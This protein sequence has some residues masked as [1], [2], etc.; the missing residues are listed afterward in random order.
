[1]D[2]ERLIRLAAAG[3]SAAGRLLYE[4]HWRSV[5][6]TAYRYVGTPQDAEDVMQ[7]TFI[8]AFKALGGFDYRTEQ[9]FSAWLGRIAANGAITLL[10]KRKRQNVDEDARMDTLPDFS[11]ADRASPAETAERRA[12]LAEVR[13]GM[14]ALSPAQR[15]VFV[16]RHLQHTEI[17]DIAAEMSCAPTSVK[18][19]LERGVAKLR[20]HLEQLWR[21]S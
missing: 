16:R 14:A 18:K 12:L 21:P 15:R 4:R 19:H 6:R 7:D 17:R 2:E 1:M 13:R 20:K 8:R 11:D 9:G 10:R 3:D 5:Y